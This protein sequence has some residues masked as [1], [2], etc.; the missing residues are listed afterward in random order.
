MQESQHERYLRFF[1]T[2]MKEISTRA[3]ETMPLTATVSRAG[4]LVGK[5][6][7]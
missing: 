6:S 2:A 5:Y 7:A 1:R 4:G 3:P